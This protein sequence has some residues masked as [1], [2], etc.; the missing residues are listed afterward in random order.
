LDGALNGTPENL[1]WVLKI[2]KKPVCMHMGGGIRNMNAIDAILKGGH[3][4][5]HF[6][7]RCF[8]RRVWAKIAF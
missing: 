2:K 5:S 6:G 8:R 7:E 4:P 3:R 1:D